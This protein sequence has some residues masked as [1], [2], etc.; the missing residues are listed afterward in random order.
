MTGPGKRGGPAYLA[1]STATPSASESDFPLIEESK[2]L[3][4][5][6]FMGI[7]NSRRLCVS[8]IPRLRLWFGRH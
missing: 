7:E 6:L 8:A 3:P 5:P 2:G 4:S 1:Q